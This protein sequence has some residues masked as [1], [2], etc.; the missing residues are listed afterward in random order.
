VKKSSLTKNIFFRLYPFHRL[1]AQK[2][3]CKQLFTFDVINSVYYE[4]HLWMPN[5]INE[6]ILCF[7]IPNPPSYIS[8]KTDV[9]TLNASVIAL[10]V[11]VLLDN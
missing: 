3:G 7:T 11:A 6:T 2:F 9:C 4:P 8:I 5:D 1:Q 10:A